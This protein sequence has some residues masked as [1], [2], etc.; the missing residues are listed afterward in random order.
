MHLHL[1]SETLLVSVLV[2]LT[3]SA[4]AL[5]GARAQAATADRPGLY[6]PNGALQSP[7]LR[8]E[9][10]DGTSFRDIETGTT[11][12]L[13]GID[14]CAPGQLAKLGRQP[15]P[16]GTMATAWLVTATLN[17][18]IACNTLRQ[19]NG[20]NLARCSSADHADI[21]A[22]MIKEG[23]AVTLPPTSEDPAIRAYVSSEQEA[24]KAYR[25]LWAS[26]FQIPWE[27]RATLSPI[28]SV[29][30]TASARQ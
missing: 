29:A 10:I 11:Y 19:A 16:C 17:K 20:I 9:V 3:I 6:Q 13:Y 15:W 27:Y 14:S 21:A 24:R 26:S 1:R 7:P 8:V 30:P 23:V 2:L 12:R 4:S 28:Q 5:E 18:W 25:G 22:D